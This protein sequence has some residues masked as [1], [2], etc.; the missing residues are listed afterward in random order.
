MKFNTKDLWVWQFS[1]DGS[2]DQ[3]I[4]QAKRA[5]CGVIVKVLDG[6][7]YQATFDH[8]PDAIDSP[9]KAATVARRFEEAGVP[10]SFWVNPRGVQD[11]SYEARAILETDRAWRPRAWYFDVEP[12]QQ[13][14]EGTP[15]QARRLIQAVKGYSKVN[16][17]DG[18]A[19]TVIAAPDA[20]PWAINDSMAAFCQEADAIAPQCY[21][22]TFETN[23]TYYA[24]Y[25]FP[26][27][28]EGVTANF[29]LATAYRFFTDNFHK[30]V[31]PILQG[32][33]N[34]AET[35]QAQ[36]VVQYVG[37]LGLSVWRA[38]VTNDEVVQ[39]LSRFTPPGA[40]DEGTVVDPEK[41]KLKTLMLLRQAAAVTASKLPDGSSVQDMQNILDF[42][43]ASK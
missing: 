7:N 4:D 23:G 8:H 12:Y 11:V 42:F 41:E 3:L 39:Q 21:W 24:R 1:E 29:V 17:A 14:W 34:G 19:A 6:V 35:K 32:D 40:T 30:P 22:R 37:G 28:P 33:S 26:P 18:L 10:C 20:R 2:I 36:D 5:G 13:F 25:G 16:H 38:G 15:D 31:L 9:K 27:G 43:K